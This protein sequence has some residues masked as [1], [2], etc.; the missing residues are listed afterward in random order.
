MKAKRVKSSWYGEV[1]RDLRLSRG[2]TQSDVARV[3]K[4]DVDT[5]G[6]I[7]T[8]LSSG[9]FDFVEKIFYALDHD[10]EVVPIDAKSESYKR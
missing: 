5:V 4:V 8:G 7:E 3:A 9:R 2:L 10:I 1:M 6:R